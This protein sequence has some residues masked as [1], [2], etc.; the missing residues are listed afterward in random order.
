MNKRM[1]IVCL[2][3]AFAMAQVAPGFAQQ[4]KALTLGY[5]FKSGAGYASSREFEFVDAVLEILNAEYGN[6]L[7]LKKFPSN[8]S[9][10]DSFLNGSIDV[11]Q[12]WPEFAVEINNR[13]GGYWP[14]VTFIFNKDP[15]L[16]LCLFQRKSDAVKT[17]G[18]LEGK[19]FMLFEDE[20]DPVPLL[21]L[22]DLLFKN[23]IDKPL[24]DFFSSFTLVPEENSMYMAV[25]MGRADALWY[26]DD[27]K[28]IFKLVSPGME[29]KLVGSFCS[30]KIY[31]RPMLALN[32]K[33]VSKSEAEKLRADTKDFIAN[34]R[35]LSKKYPKLQAL[36]AYKNMIKV[37]FALADDNNFAADFDLYKR[38]QA[39]GWLREMEIL[40]KYIMDAPLGKPVEIR[41]DYD[42][43]KKM[44][45]KAK[46]RMNC[47]D[48]CMK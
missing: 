27:I 24:W 32:K 28:Y 9:V 38:S 42:D 33:T 25:A 35:T 17:I 4:K 47:I 22:R 6:N 36:Y 15:G 31:R 41:L 29:A 12:L 34:F 26:H 5:H 13:G 30:E 7:N 23:G 44:C 21:E 2:S 14:W 19:R 39:N 11:I 20:V 1:A 10:I 37:D 45:E 48:K 3:L 18:E 8:G 40:K 16:S 46:N 43:C